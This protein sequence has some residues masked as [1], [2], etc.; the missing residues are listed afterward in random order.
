MTRLR[1][2]RLP[3]HETTAPTSKHDRRRVTRI[4]PGRS[5]SPEVPPVSAARRPW[6]GVVAVHDGLFLTHSV[7][8]ASGQGIYP[9]VSNGERRLHSLLLSLPVGPLAVSE[10]PSN[11]S[12]EHTSERTVS[13]GTRYR[14]RNTAFG[15]RYRGDAV[16][17]RRG[18]RSRTALLVR[19]RSLLCVVTIQTRRYRAEP[20]HAVCTTRPRSLSCSRSPPR[21]ITDLSSGRPEYASATTR[22]SPYRTSISA[23]PSSSIS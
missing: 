23:A 6:R 18:R 12:R 5:V 17:R 2:G 21:P 19:C 13:R 3:G 9:V 7:E 20:T 1:T 10:L 16:T 4:R 22:P 8:P 15:S 11:G 14:Y